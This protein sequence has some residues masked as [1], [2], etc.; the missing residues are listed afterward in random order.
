MSGSARANLLNVAS[1]EC[2]STKLV[3]PANADGSYLVHKLEGTGPCFV[4]SRM[5]LGGP[6]LSSTEIGKIRSWIAQGALDN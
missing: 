2:G 5:P 3:A 6:F 1:T 4:G